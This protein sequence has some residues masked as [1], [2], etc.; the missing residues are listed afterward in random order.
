[1]SFFMKNV[2]LVKDEIMTKEIRNAQSVARSD[3]HNKKYFHKF[4]T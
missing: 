1:M 4:T 2:I 3:M